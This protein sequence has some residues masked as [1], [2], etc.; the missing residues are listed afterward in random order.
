ML[1]AGDTPASARGRQTL[2]TTPA[3]LMSAF[4]STVFLLLILWIVCLGVVIR[5]LRSA[6]CS[7]YAFKRGVQISE[8]LLRLSSFPRFP[9]V[10]RDGPRRKNS[11]LGC[12]MYVRVSRPGG[13]SRCW[14]CRIL[15]ILRLRKRFSGQA[16]PGRRGRLPLRGPLSRTVKR[17]GRTVCERKC[18][19]YI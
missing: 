10:G 18:N 19:K 13:I 5:S 2:G 3:A 1:S 15:R 6:G 9:D 16:L 12:C 8:K 11:S 17:S 7:S 14:E 4:L